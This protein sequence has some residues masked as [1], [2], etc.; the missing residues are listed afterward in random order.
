MGRKLDFLY[1]LSDHIRV[2][3]GFNFEGA[4]VCP[5]VNGIRDAGYSSLVNHFCRLC[6]RD[7][8]LEVC[9]LLPISK[10]QWEFR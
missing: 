3:A 2:V 4:V 5:E 9:I 1:L 8:E 6:P 10:Q 7:G